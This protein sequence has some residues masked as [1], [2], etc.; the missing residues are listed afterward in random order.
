[1]EI[2]S[3]NPDYEGIEKK[4]A[5]YEIISGRAS[6]E[7]HSARIGG[8]CHRSDGLTLP[9]ARQSIWARRRH[10]AGIEHSVLFTGT[11]YHGALCP[12][13]AVWFGVAP[14]SRPCISARGPGRLLRRLKRATFSRQRS[15]ASQ[16]R[17]RMHCREGIAS[18][19]TRIRFRPGSDRMLP[20]GWGK[21]LR[22]PCQTEHYRIR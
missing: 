1:M 14:A 9:E 6:A 4:T 8:A 18:P 19:G 13:S 7:I 5:K 2:E 12:P 16:A 20:L 17:S 15:L 22:S 11:R 21:P 3:K 10:S